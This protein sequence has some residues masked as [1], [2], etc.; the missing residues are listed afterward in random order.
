[1]RSTRAAGLAPFIGVMT[2]PIP[3]L[4]LRAETSNRRSPCA[5]PSLI[6]IERR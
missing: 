2:A 6:Q 4:V 1:M 3:D 5:A